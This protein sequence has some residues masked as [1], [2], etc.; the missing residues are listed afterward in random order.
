MERGQYEWDKFYSEFK[1]RT[2]PAA[3]E[4]PVF[5]DDGS[6]EAVLRQIH[7]RLAHSCEKTLM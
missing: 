6:K 1:N 4:K 7:R 3:H 5:R 2:P